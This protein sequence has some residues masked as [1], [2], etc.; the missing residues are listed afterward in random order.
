M[1]YAV[2]VW[3]A[4]ALF[5]FGPKAVVLWAFLAGVGA[6]FALRSWAVVVAQ[7]RTRRGTATQTRS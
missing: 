5:D 2:D 4:Q 7:R 6:G 1:P 3:L